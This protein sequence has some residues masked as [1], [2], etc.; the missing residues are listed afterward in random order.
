MTDAGA[1][2]GTVMG[3]SGGGV[4]DSRVVSCPRSRGQCQ[5]VLR[6][7]NVAMNFV[8]GR[9]WQCRLKWTPL[10]SPSCLGLPQASAVE[11]ARCE[12]T[13]RSQQKLRDGGPKRNRWV[14]SDFNDLRTK[15]FTSMQ[16]GVRHTARCSIRLSV[17]LK[18][19][20][21][22]CSGCCGRLFVVSFCFGGLEFLD[23]FPRF[24]RRRS[25]LFSFFSPCRSL[26][27]FQTPVKLSAASS[28]QCKMGLSQVASCTGNK[29]RTKPCTSK[30]VPHTSVPGK[31]PSFF[32]ARNSL[33][34]N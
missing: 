12:K 14:K 6:K 9:L 18:Q 26:A 34:F 10:A 1:C 28:N 16:T 30:G 33:F 24:S 4:A 25:L 5:N 20:L 17:L 31:R 22:S 21:L 29:Q 7:N 23:K 27:I 15:W 32:L 3:L 19:L 8:C 2:A 11:S 13:T